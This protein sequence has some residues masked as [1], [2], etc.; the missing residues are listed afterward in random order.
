MEG[1]SSNTLY[2]ANNKR[3]IFN[4][5]LLTVQT[6]NNPSRHII[7]IQHILHQTFSVGGIWQLFAN[8][9]A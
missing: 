1:K 9:V 7:N 5:E 8:A 3:L 6:P 4:I 2:N